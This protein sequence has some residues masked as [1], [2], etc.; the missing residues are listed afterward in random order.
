MPAAAKTLAADQM[1]SALT[2]EYV[3]QASHANIDGGCAHYGAGGWQNNPEYRVGGFWCAE[4]TGANWLNGTS[5]RC[6]SL[7]SLLLQ[8]L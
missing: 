6:G 2:R 3:L 4:A 7:S 8:P 5:W 1:S